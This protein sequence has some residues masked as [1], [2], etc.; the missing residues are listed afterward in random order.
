ME[1]FMRGLRFSLVLGGAALLMAGGCSPADEPRDGTAQPEMVAQEGAPTTV[2]ED[3]V[4]TAQMVAL[5]G[6]GV[7][8]EVHV[9]PA[10]GGSLVRVMLTGAP[11]GVLQGHI[12]GGTCMERTRALMP[13]EPVTTDPAGSGES[14]TTLDVAIETLLDGNHIVV[15]HEAGGAPGASVVCGE[16][17]RR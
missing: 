15:Y 16:L 17:P 4:V 9:E 13:L 10:N 1:V 6:S 14:M 12:H 8:G 11:Q 2:G 7:T 5:E 3:D